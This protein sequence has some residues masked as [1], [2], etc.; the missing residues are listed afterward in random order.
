MPHCCLAVLH[1]AFAVLFFGRF[2]DNSMSTQVLAFAP[3]ALTDGQSPFGRLCLWTTL[4]DR[5]LSRS[6]Q[7]NCFER[8]SARS[9]G[10]RIPRTS[11]PA[12]CH[13]TAGSSGVQ[14]QS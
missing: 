10:L 5:F 8:E 3:K 14:T 13:G 2:V 4:R 6:D 9:M 12:D 11:P 7:K 1:F